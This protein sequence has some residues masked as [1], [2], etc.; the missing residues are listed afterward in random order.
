MYSAYLKP[1]KKTH[2]TLFCDKEF[3]SSIFKMALDSHFDLTWPCP[4]IEN[5][6]SEMDSAYLKTPK[7]S[8]STSF[9]VSG[10]K[11]KFTDG[12]MQIMRVAESCQLGNKAEYVLGPH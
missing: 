8:T 1:L 3:K 5:L 9:N 2:Y 6:A 4:G 11:G 12:F 10:W 7:K